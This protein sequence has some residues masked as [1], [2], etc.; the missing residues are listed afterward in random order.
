MLVCLDL[1]AQLARLGLRAFKVKMASLA[2]RVFLD[3]RENRATL[4]TVVH[5][6]M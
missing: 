4:A 1:L 6:V 3:P 2:S 5:L